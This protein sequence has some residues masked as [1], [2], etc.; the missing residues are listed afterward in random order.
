MKLDMSADIIQ[1]DRILKQPLEKSVCTWLELFYKAKYVLGAA[2]LRCEAP[3]EY[4][5][6]HENYEGLC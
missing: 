4:G 3:D 6:L 5:N 2:C 1:G